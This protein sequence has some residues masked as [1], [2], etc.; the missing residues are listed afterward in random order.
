MRLSWRIPATLALAVAA[1][2]A[3]SAVEPLRVAAVAGR[4]L[5]E[6]DQRVEAMLGRQELAVRQVR[7]DPLLPGRVHERFAQLHR[8][9]PVY[10]GE[11]VRQRAG[12]LP[13]SIF[14]SLFE[15]IGIGVAPAL[16]PE[17][18][19]RAVER[20]GGT[21]FGRDGGPELV[22]LP[23]SGGYLLAYKVR[24][25][26][27]TDIRLFFV[28]AVSG[29]IALER[30]DL[31][32]QA[33]GSGTGVLNDRK[34]V[35][36][37]ASGGGFVADDKLRPPA[38]RTY[39]FKGDIFKILFLRGVFDLLDSDL[40]ADSDNNW[41]DGANVDAHVYAGYTYDY[42]YKR[43]GRRGLDNADITI[44]S[45]THPVRREDIF[46]FPNI[47][48]IGILYLNAFYAGD[49]LMV[50]GEGLPDFLTDTQGRNWNYV[51]GALDIV[52]HELTHGVTDYSSRLVYQDE[53]GALNE[54]FSDIMATS[55]EFY[56]QQPGSGPLRA[57]YLLGEDVIT[58]GGIRSMQNPRAYGDP[59]HYDERFT[60]PEDNGGVHINSGIPNQ[61]FYLAI[62]GGVN[63]F[64]GLSVTG[65]GGANREQIERVFYRAFVQLL[66]ATANFAA[67]RAATVQAARDLF[68]AGSAPERAVTQ[69][70]TAVGV[71]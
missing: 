11:V 54:S 62:E 37:A 12:R 41:T 58:P 34:K 66:P 32:T 46:S 57:D 55:V 67:A 28:D 2:V 38:I 44:S 14:A 23:V 36:A 19:L 18:V 59:L 48:Y 64:S 71:D 1:P 6:W 42:Y 24:A 17:A 63:A 22:V 45:I 30:S 8:G 39:D 5:A 50:Y 70:W 25:V 53:P 20:R 60:G 35:S 13:V 33:V 49:G 29:A 47:E 51:A 52:A 43:F 9:V 26:T 27:R 69:A 3:V 40:A 68:G 16:S 56:F 7:E 4:Q 31:Q 21:A 65:V 61:A 15:G 10:G